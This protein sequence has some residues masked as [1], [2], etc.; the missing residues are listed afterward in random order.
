M[1]NTKCF[2]HAQWTICWSGCSKVS[3][4]SFVKFPI[5]LPLSQSLLLISL[6]LFGSLP[7]TFTRL[8][9]RYSYPVLMSVLL[10]LTQCKRLFVTTC[11]GSLKLIN[12]AIK[13]YMIRKII[14]YVSGIISLAY[15][16]YYHISNAVVLPQRDVLKKK[17]YQIIN[18]WRSFE[19]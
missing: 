8:L 15:D 19:K 6:C 12:K 13:I 14:R 18:S 4:G 7:F 11:R 16:H 9:Q 2:E 1:V 17:S 10:N 5:D 3:L